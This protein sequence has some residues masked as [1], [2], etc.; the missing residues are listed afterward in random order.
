MKLALLGASKIAARVLPAFRRAQGVEW[1]GVAAGRSERA[2]A[3]GQKHALP[4]FESYE[5]LTAERRIDAVY[6]SVLNSDHARLIE[7]ALRAGK[8]VLCEKPLVL[9]HADAKRLFALARSS[10]LIL[11]EGFMY[12][13]HPQITQLM[14]IVREGQIGP[15]RSVH[16]SMSFILETEGT[17]RRTRD[18]G[19]GAIS[20]VGCYPVDFSNWIMGET[21]LEAKVVHSVVGEVETRAMA[22]LTYPNRLWTQ[23]DFGIDQAAANIWEVRGERGSVSAP[24][25][26]TQG[27]GNQEIRILNE[28][29]ELSIEMVPGRGLDQFTCELEAFVRAVQGLGAAPITP[30][31]SIR[32]AWTLEQLRSQIK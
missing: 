25:H 28:D 27:S 26:D 29:S 4:A 17:A 13:F 20:D 19:G 21:P 9:T 14:K 3:F 32:N 15:I 11:M 31:E 7:L 24:R 16:A 2:R 1:V 18:G 23:L 12:R 8:H 5:A 22:I 10:G 6:I 30:E